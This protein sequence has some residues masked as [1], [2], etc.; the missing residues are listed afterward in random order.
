MASLIG[1]L[2]LVGVARAGLL[3]TSFLQMH[4]P[5]RLTGPYCKSHLSML[6]TQQIGLVP[7]LHDCHELTSMV[8]GR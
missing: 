2:S 4:V 6:G 7:P 1:S 5:P 3:R 8:P